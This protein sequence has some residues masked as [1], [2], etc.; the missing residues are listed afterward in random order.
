MDFGSE[1]VVLGVSRCMEVRG[2]RS[3]RSPGTVQRVD[4][5]RVDAQH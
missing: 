2:R 3:E 5:K 1:Q 4:S